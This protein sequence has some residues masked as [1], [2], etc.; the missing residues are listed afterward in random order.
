MF[1]G[2]CGAVQERPRTASRVS[3][4]T[5]LLAAATITILVLAG[6]FGSGLIQQ[7]L[8]KSPLSLP[9]Q[10]TSTSAASSPTVT[11]SQTSAETSN[12]PST[13]ETSSS[14]SSLPA[15]PP[16]VL[17]SIQNWPSAVGCYYY[18]QA[19]WEYVTCLSRE[20]VLK[21]HLFPGYFLGI[22]SYQPASSFTLPPRLTYGIVMVNIQLFGSETDS[23]SGDGAYSIQLNTNFFFGNNGQTD[24]VQF[25]YQAIPKDDK[26][27]FCVWNVDTQT[28]DY[29]PTCMDPGVVNLSEMHTIWVPQWES[30][31]IGSWTVNGNL[32]GCGW[33]NGHHGFV[34]VVAPDKYGLAT[35]TI[36]WVEASGGIMGAGDSSLAKFENT[37]L[38]TDIGATSCG[39]PLLWIYCSGPS[40]SADDHVQGVTGESN[41]LKQYDESLTSYYSG[42]HWWLSTAS[43][44][45]PASAPSLST[46]SCAQFV[47]YSEPF[48]NTGI[49]LFTV[50]VQPAG[51]SVKRGQRCE[52][53][54]DCHFG[55]RCAG[56]AD[57]NDR[58][59]CHPRPRPILHRRLR[60][61]LR[62][63]M[64][65]QSSTPAWEQ[66]H[67]HHEHTHLPGRASGQLRYHNQGHPTPEHRASS[68]LAPFALSAEQQRRN[69][70][71]YKLTINPPG[72]PSPVIV[73]PVSG[74]SL[75][76]GENTLIGYAPSTDTAYPGWVSCSRMQ[77]Q[78]TLLDGSTMT[79]TPTED[80]TFQQTGY[81][82]ATVNL[83][84][85]G[86]ATV[87]L[88]AANLAGVQGTISVVVNIFKAQP[89]APFTFALSV[90]P[91]TYAIMPGGQGSVTVLVTV[92]GGIPQPV[93][94]SVSGLPQDATYTLSSNP[95]TPT[96]AL[97]LTINAATDT[98]LGSYTI[99][100][101]G[102]GG[103]STESTTIQLAVASL[104]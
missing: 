49:M 64:H 51:G 102:T 60:G 35:S 31:I 69:S 65:V 22:H 13:A 82:D 73:S 101:T 48:G 24:W 3:S 78:V 44:C 70:A 23:K 25:V 98:P 89:T 77:F 45:D 52:D 81:C 21:Y 18:G 5:K 57:N 75:N 67:P 95:V 93:Q 97:T 33:L 66:L 10:S 103:G 42:S 20:A 68:F 32:I 19:G 17:A 72:P 79:A 11:T 54:G 2:K 63:D 83:T 56:G 26:S 86:A 39:T 14:T 40:I 36:G 104:G 15:T 100:I 8:S 46:P 94:L 53:D 29:D 30:Y 6:L 55:R 28:Q 41:N 96:A 16:P 85:Q 38:Q 50:D 74:S 80:S 12:I 90:T 61:S 84:V 7:M 1:C 58:A 91:S 62:Q 59:R 47:D 43:G 9:S 88:S 71:V 92:T 34:C 99:T 87:T 4:R 37:H 27:F 76:A